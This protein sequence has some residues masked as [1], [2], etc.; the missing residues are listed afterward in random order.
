ME[1]F[2]PYEKLSK[3]KKRELDSKKRGSWHGVSPVTKRAESKKTY[4][5]KRA[6]HWKDELPLQGSLILRVYR[7]RR[8]G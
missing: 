4:N 7:V 3:R 2:I 8:S 6:L 5:R 1:K